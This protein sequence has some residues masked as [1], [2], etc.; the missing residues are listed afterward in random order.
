L[1]NLQENLT[2]PV[3]VSGRPKIH[4][5]LLKAYPGSVKRVDKMAELICR[6]AFPVT[7]AQMNY[8]L[9]KYNGKA[10]AAQVRRMMMMMMMRL[11]MMVTTTMVTVDLLPSIQSCS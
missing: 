1:E 2:G 3:V 10:G 8:F 9:A 11:V 5:I 7:T 6:S 4:E